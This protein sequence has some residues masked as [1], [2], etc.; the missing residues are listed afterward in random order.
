[1]TGVLVAGMAGVGVMILEITNLGE[2]F[3]IYCFFFYGWRMFD[4]E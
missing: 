1:M 3:G 2:G 4:S